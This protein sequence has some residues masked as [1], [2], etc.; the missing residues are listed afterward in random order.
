MNV[1]LDG[2]GVERFLVSDFTRGIEGEPS[3]L[4]PGKM[5]SSRQQFHCPRCDKPSIAQHGVTNRCDCGLHWVAYGNAL[6]IWTA[7]SMP[8]K[9]LPV[10]PKDWHYD[11]RGYCDNPARGY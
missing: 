10:Q 4:L 5:Q 7:E 2:P 8:R 1:D 3:A 9:Q 11:S 6:H